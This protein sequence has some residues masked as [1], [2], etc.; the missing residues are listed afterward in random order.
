MVRS[1]SLDD[2]FSY[3]LVLTCKSNLVFLFKCSSQV[4]LR[5]P[6]QV[7]YLLIHVQNKVRKWIVIRIDN[8]IT[9]VDPNVS[10]CYVS[11]DMSW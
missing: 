4:E 6:I 8:Q 11:S 2:F 9:G 3:C 7:N 1:F 10:G 5:A